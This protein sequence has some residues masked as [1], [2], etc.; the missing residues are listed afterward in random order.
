METTNLFSE[1][2]IIHRSDHNGYA[3]ASNGKFLHGDGTWHIYLDGDKLNHE[4]VQGMSGLYRTEMIAQKVL[5]K[6]RPKI[7]LHT[8]KPGECFRFLPPNDSSVECIKT[9]EGYLT[10]LMFHYANTKNDEVERIKPTKFPF[11]KG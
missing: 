7:Y 10:H 4:T 8:L 9:N 11:L 5:E 6:Y 3:I 1:A 2:K